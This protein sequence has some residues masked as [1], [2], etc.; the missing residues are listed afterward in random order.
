MTHKGPGGV[1]LAAGLVL[2]APAGAP[3]ADF[4]RIFEDRCAACHGHAGG[5]ARQSLAEAED[6]TLRGARSGR[7]VAGFL[8]RHAG[9][10]PP[11]EIALFVDVFRAQ[12][13][14]G[15]FYQ[16][17][18]AICHDRAYE[19][20]RL[21]LILREGRLFG[22]YSGRDIAD[23]LPGHARMTEAEAERMLEALIALRKGWR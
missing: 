6:G 13:R 9:G 1:L 3:A 21:R 15:G 19:F 7:D 10:L 11:E 4:H 20:A 5:F 16:E 23:F 18:C 12:L 17:R 22:R 8:A 14:S 2:L